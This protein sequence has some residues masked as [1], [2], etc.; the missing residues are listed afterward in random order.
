M[1]EAAAAQGG[2]GVQLGAAHVLLRLLLLG[3]Q[4]LC[5]GAKCGAIGVT[6]LVA[7][8]GL[9]TKRPRNRFCVFIRPQGSMHSR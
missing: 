6:L 5:A 3:L 7:L 9:V 8:Q 4:Q 2:S 1:E